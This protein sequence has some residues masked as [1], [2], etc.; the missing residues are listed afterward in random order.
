[1]P[2][3]LTA[4]LPLIFYFIAYNVVPSELNARYTLFNVTGYLL[5]YGILFIILDLSLRAKWHQMGI[6]KSLTWKADEMNDKGKQDGV[7]NDTGS[8]TIWTRI[9]SLSVVHSEYYIYN[10]DTCYIYSTSTLV[11]A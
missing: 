4:I 8:F 5:V 1:M 7:P 2:L 9:V 10:L 11:P 3:C 6:Q